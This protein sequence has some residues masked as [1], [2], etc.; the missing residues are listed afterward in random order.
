MEVLHVRWT[1]QLCYLYVQKLDEDQK[2][3]SV[4]SNVNL[5]TILLQTAKA[6]ISSVDGKKLAEVRMLLDS[7]S[8]QTYISH[9]TRKL[10]NLKT[11]EK[12]SLIHI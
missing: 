9:E 2:S 8:Q 11:Q 4:S 12:L 10:L 1:S 6:E 5:N 3:E 7:R